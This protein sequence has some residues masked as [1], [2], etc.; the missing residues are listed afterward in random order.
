M[1]WTWKTTLTAIEEKF[2]DVLPRMEWVNM[3]GGHH[4]TRPGVSHSPAGGMHPVGPEK[5]GVTVYLEPGEACALNAYYLATRVL[6]VTRNGDVNI[7]I[8]TPAPPAIC[9][10]S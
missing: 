8:L 3:G 1:P 6:D 2:G 7:A 4:I 9:R 5:W 10:T